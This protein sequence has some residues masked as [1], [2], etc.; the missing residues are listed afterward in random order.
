MDPLKKNKVYKEYLG[1]YEEYLRIE[2]LVLLTKEDQF[3]HKPVVIDKDNIIV[4]FK[5]N[6]FNIRKPIYQTFSI[7]LHS[8]LKDKEDLMKAYNFEKKQIVYNGK[9]DFKEIQ[10]ITNNINDITKN[11]KDISDKLNDNKMDI[12]ATL[13]TINNDNTKIRK[14][15]EDMYNIIVDTFDDVSQKQKINDYLKMNIEVK[16]TSSINDYMMIVDHYIV[17]PPVLQDVSLDKADESEKKLKEKLKKTKKVTKTE[18]ELKDGMKEGIKKI[19]FKTLDE[20]NSTKRSKAF[21]LNKSQLHEIIENDA[22][23]K[24]KVGKLFKKMSRA[25]LCDKLLL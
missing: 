18:K 14:E 19:I 17:S 24:K 5:K 15:H 25:E 20:C 6:K 21:Y 23:L 8:Y 10:R 16:H 4:N 7:K 13:V 12:N 3:D 22:E 2:D 1:L 11:I 9:T